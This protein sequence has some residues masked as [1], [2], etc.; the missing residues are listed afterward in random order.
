MRL[1]EIKSKFSGKFGFESDK[2][3]N[4][5]SVFQVHEEIW[6]ELTTTETTQS[7]VMELQEKA[8]GIL[9][10]NSVLCSLKLAVYLSLPEVSHQ[11]PHPRSRST[12]LINF[13]WWS[14]VISL[15]KIW[16]WPFF[17][18]GPTFPDCCSHL[19]LQDK[20]ALK[21][22]AGASQSLSLISIV[23]QL[24]GPFA[25]FSLSSLFSLFWL[26]AHHVLFLPRTHSLC[27][28][29]MCLCAGTC[30]TNPWAGHFS[31]FNTTLISCM[32]S[33]D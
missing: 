15:P 32:T 27:L 13:P 16:F 18:S 19:V 8:D 2:D 7:D 28:V 11:W 17:C 12:L 5:G 31:P 26:I 22:P 23:L 6:C 9:V 30:A 25:H 10:D 29:C 33:S 24:D 20:T 14:F 4:R 1:H 3:K 21:S